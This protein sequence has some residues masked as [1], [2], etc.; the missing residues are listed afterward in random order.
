MVSRRMSWTASRLRL[1]S[2]SGCVNSQS[3]SQSRRA[4]AAPR[5]STPPP[6]SWPC[7]DLHRK[8]Q[9]DRDVPGSGWAFELFLRANGLERSPDTWPPA[10]D[11]YLESVRLDPPYAPSWARLGRS[12]IPTRRRPRRICTARART[13]ALRTKNAPA[14][15]V[16][17]G[18]RGFSK[19]LGGDAGCPP[20]FRRLFSEVRGAMQ[21][22]VL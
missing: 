1:K 2:S 18:H 21:G 16:S 20:R 19:D 3:L 9:L 22:S 17:L 6:R 4:V 8:P 7:V 14:P 12:G 5:P 13:A 11:L 15:G 10:R